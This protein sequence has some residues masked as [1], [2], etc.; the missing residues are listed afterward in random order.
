[1]QIFIVTENAFSNQFY[2]QHLFSSG[3]TDSRSFTDSGSCLTACEM[4]GVP[5]IV[6]LEIFRQWSDTAALL[7]SIK[8]FDPAI[9]VVLITEAEDKDRA[10]QL[11]E[12]GAF[13]Y[14]LKNAGTGRC[15]TS[16]I[17]RIKGLKASLHQRMPALHKEK[18]FIPCR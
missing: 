11:L 1:M 16:M 8:R 4:H 17:E 3:F 13:D 7:E 10:D 6:F 15:M 5:E 2:E 14:L 18:A 9:Y 12:L